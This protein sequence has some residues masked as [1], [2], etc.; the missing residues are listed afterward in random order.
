MVSY[1]VIH[2]SP[3]CIWIFS[4]TCS[5]RSIACIVSS[6]GP[7]MLDDAAVHGGQAGVLGAVCV[8]LVTASG[9][10]RRPWGIKR[11]FHWRQCWFRLC[12]QPA[13]RA[14]FEVERKLPRVVTAVRLSVIA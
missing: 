8:A 3:F 6:R 12:F 7:R 5:A 9:R 14:G 4:C 11:S 2:Y 10:G 1:F 13:F